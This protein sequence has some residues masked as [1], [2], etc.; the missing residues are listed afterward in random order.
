LSP[1]SRQAAAL[2]LL[3]AAMVA[4]ALGTAFTRSTIPRSFS[5]EVEKLQL[6]SAGKLHRIRTRVRRHT[7]GND[8]FLLTVNGRR[9]VIDRSVATML[10]PG[11]A[12]EKKRF[13]RTL[14]VN[15]QS[16]RLPLSMD[17]HHMLIAY[18]LLGILLTLAL[19]GDRMSA[20]LPG[21]SARF[22]LLQVAFLARAGELHP[23]TDPRTSSRL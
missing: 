8:Y 11:D 7:G 13:S 9:V 6:S 17:F 19:A 2:V 23:R 18:P 20:R 5:E 21:S 10:R 3:F 4:L 15:G 12:I 1:F 14:R 22:R 16:R